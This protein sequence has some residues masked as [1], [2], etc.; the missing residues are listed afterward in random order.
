MENSNTIYY[1]NIEYNYDKLS[2]EYY[3][4]KLILLGDHKVGKSSFIY[5]FLLGSIPTN[6]TATIGIETCKKKYNEFE[7]NF[8]DTA[9][10]QKYRA[11]ITS[12]LRLS[13]IIF[14]CF[15]LTLEETFESVKNYFY[16]IK[17]NL[18]YSNLYIIVLVALK[19]DKC[20]TTNFE[21]YS[22]IDSFITQENIF[23][24]ETSIFFE[25]D[26][27]YKQISLEDC[28]E[29]NKDKDNNITYNNLGV[30]K[31]K[32][33]NINN[34]E[35][36]HYDPCDNTI[37]KTNYKTNINTAVSTPYIT[38]LAS[39]RKFKTYYYRGGINVLMDYTISQLRKKLNL[40]AVTKYDDNKNEKI[41][42]NTVKISDDKIKSNFCVCRNNCY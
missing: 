22:A 7:I 19:V 39:Q 38:P 21:L 3:P 41:F 14:L 40:Q 13:D 36:D 6:T 42:K 12:L 29:I 2:S 16:T 18:K 23:Y 4:I 8:L 30:S 33:I 34:T 35:S 31:E 24:S 26:F 20:V 25:D 11:D 10:I 17:D 37:F 9:G 1:N 15:D 5:K 27:I 32:F 28:G